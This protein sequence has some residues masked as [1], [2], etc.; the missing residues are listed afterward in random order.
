M[1]QWNFVILAAILFFIVFVFRKLAP[2]GLIVQTAGVRVLFAFAMIALF[3]GFTRPTSPFA[4]VWDGLL[5]VFAIATCF[6]FLRGVREFAAVA[7]TGVDS[8]SGHREDKG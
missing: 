4:Y 8:R 6:V 5:V 2:K 1:I 3:A 7:R